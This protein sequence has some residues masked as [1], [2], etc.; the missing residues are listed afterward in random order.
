MVNISLPLDT[1]L[2]PNRVY[3]LWLFSYPSS[4]VLGFGLLERVKINVVKIIFLIK[5]FKTYISD[6]T[7]QGHFI[8]SPY[9]NLHFVSLS[10]QVYGCLIADKYC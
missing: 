7:S 1:K 8:T 4:M 9:T 2:L 10:L 3:I 6:L 5:I